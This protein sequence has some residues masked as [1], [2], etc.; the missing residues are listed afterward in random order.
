M[1]KTV[2]IGVI[3][4]GNMGALHTRV[5]E[6][7]QGVE[8]VGIYDIDA[9][10]AGEVAARYGTQAFKSPD[11]LIAACDGVIIAAPSTLHHEHAARCIDAGTAVL[12]EKPVAVTV[13]EGED[14]VRRAQQAGVVAH[15]GHIE[16]FNPTFGE[17]ARVLKGRT[18]R[19]LA[20]R[21][22]SPFTPQAQD[23]DVTLDLMI[24]DLDL[25]LT[26]GGAAPARIAAEAH[27]IQARQPDLVTALLGLE[28]GISVTLTASKASFE[29]VRIIEAHA[30]DASIRADLLTREVWVHQRIDDSYR[31]E[32]SFVTYQQQTVVERIFAAPV[33]P[34]RAEHRAF[35]DAIR[36]LEDRGVSL[37]DGTRSLKAALD[38][39]AAYGG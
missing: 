17:I 35:T 9:D 11:E 37:A 16:R 18:L 14:L 6:D 10:R 22:T 8:L 38:I 21:R 2:R 5:A 12:V 24:H 15:V 4:A 27:T 32:G 20:L 19:S 28:N 23:I 31:E 25:A 30:D 1:I 13:A 7:S 36:G 39:I 29:K 34:L 33:E 26:L 3:G